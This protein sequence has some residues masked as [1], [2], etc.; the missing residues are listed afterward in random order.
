MILYE[1]ITKGKE[2]KKPITVT[3]LNILFFIIF[4][5]FAVI[6][7][8]LAFVQLINGDEYSE[9]AEYTRTKT[10]PISAP[11]GLIKDANNVV[12]ASN[13][14]VWTITFEI[15]DEIEQDFDGIAT[16]L[17]SLLAET[18]EELEEKKMKY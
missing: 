13:E 12:L 16:I 15:N 1:T 5:L 18:E 14:T 8:R 11:R 17:A 4:I 3:R 2:K 9:L 7:F 6:I 10:I